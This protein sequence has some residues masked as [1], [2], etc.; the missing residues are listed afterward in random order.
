MV[1]SSTPSVQT[2]VAK[3]CSG[4]S[5]RKATSAVA[6]FSVRCGIE[7]FVLSSATRQPCRPE[8]RSARPESRKAACRSRASAM[9]QAKV[10]V[11]ASGTLHR[12]LCRATRSRVRRVSR[13]N[14][15]KLFRS[16][17][18]LRATLMHRDSM[19]MCMTRRGHRPSIITE[20]SRR[21]R[22]NAAQ[23]LVSSDVN[24]G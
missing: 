16:D 20:F 6:S 24:C 9:P 4:P 1:L 14:N 5:V 12:N 10:R 11:L 13:D 22:R 3:R 15:S 2:P 17:S 18:S 7:L 19:R 23:D 21:F 8:F